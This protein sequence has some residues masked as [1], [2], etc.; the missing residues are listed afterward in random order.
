PKAAVKNPR[1]GVGSDWE[2][3]PKDFTFYSIKYINQ[4]DGFYLRRGEDVI[5]RTNGETETIVRHKKHVV[6]DQVVEL[7]TLSLTETEFPVIYT[8]SGGQNLPVTLILTIDGEGNIT[9]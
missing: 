6:D 3:L 5:T 9:V 8:D 1:K 4:W 2:V 7:N